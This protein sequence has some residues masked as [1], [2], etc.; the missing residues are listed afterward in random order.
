MM[1]GGLS[2]V[3]FVCNRS[4]LL[5]VAFEINGT[6]ASGPWIHPLKC[7]REGRRWYVREVL[8]RAVANELLVPNGVSPSQRGCGR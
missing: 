5:C 6:A 8:K 2:R 3:N 4:E 1:A 7:R